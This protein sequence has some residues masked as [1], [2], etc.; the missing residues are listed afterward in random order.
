MIQID[1]A[2]WG[3]M[4]GGVIIGIYRE[5]TG[6]FRFE[7]VLVEYFQG[8]KYHDKEYLFNAGYIALKLL[9]E[10]RVTHI[11][12]IKMCTGYCLDGIEEYLAAA[13]YKFTRGKITGPLQDKIEH[14]LRTVLACKY[15]FK[16]T[17]DELTKPEKKGLFWWKQIAWLKD[18][19]V[20]A[21]KPNPLKAAQCKTGWST[22]NTWATY[23]YADAK[24]L[25][26]RLKNQIK[27]SKRGYNNY[28]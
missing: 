6:E 11:E 21:R 20:N 9:N 27:S 1:D 8:Q 19:N 12:P 10:L 28:V 15:D 16:V 4:I 18:G 17:Y 23:P 13:D 7:E 24:I 3:S 22:F 5:E 14:A 2:G 25:A 26:S